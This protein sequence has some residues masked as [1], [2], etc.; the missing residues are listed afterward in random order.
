MARGK[1]RREKAPAE[2]GAGERE[3]GYGLQSW[4]LVDVHWLGPSALATANKHSAIKAIS[5]KFLI[6]SFLVRFHAIDFH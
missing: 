6:S 1:F 4:P 5:R 3:T 2:A